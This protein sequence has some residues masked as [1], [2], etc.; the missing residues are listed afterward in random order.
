LCDPESF[1]PGQK[2]STCTR[3]SNADGL[4]DR[5]PFTLTLTPVDRR[6]FTAD[7]SDP[8][9]GVRGAFPDI[10]V[11]RPESWKN[12]SEDGRVINSP[13]QNLDVHSYRG[14]SYAV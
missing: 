13:F 7:D 11:A 5:G 12:R 9:S 14:G 1:K 8:A 6:N 10:V 2:E 3:P 4:Q